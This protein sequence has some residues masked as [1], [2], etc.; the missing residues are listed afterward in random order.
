MC[1]LIQLFLLLVKFLSIPNTNS[2]IFDGV[3]FE[4]SC[5]RYNCMSLLT[6]N[7]SSIPAYD[8]INQITQVR[9][10]IHISVYTGICVSW[11]YL[12]LHDIT[13]CEVHI[14]IL[15]KKFLFCFGVVTAWEESRPPHF[16]VV[17]IF[18][19]TESDL[20]GSCSRISFRIIR[21]TLVRRRCLLFVT[22]PSC[23]HSIIFILYNC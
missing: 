21:G 9:R 19:Y 10:W 1:W 20:L 17:V 18:S 6:I 16:F 13:G 11:I 8:S 15:L 7:I 22:T 12:G 14:W 23:N 3:P 5:I 4:S 2:N